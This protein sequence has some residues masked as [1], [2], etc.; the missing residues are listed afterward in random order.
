MLNNKKKY[1]EIHSFIFLALFYKRNGFIFEIKF[2]Y[3]VMYEI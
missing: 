1:F 2:Y 3:L